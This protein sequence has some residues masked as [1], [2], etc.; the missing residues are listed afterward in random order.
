MSDLK[1]IVKCSADMS[2][3]PSGMSPEEATAF[4]AKGELPASSKAPVTTLVRGVDYDTDSSSMR[5]SDRA[6]EVLGLKP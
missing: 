4:F 3:V 5:M 1:T 6:R 2:G